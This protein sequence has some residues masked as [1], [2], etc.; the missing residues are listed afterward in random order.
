MCGFNAEYLEVRGLG[1]R[2]V[3]G[4]G[5]FEVRGFDGFEPHGSMD[6]Y[7]TQVLCEVEPRGF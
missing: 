3:H 6:F 1:G 5:R 2:K 7:E 4:F